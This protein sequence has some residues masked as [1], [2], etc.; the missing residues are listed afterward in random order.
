MTY[1]REEFI[2]NETIARLQSIINP[3]STGG[4]DAVDFTNDDNLFNVLKAKVN[5]DRVGASNG[6][7]CVTSKSLS[8]KW[9][10]STE[11]TRRTVK[12]T[13]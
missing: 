6:R 9:F 5:V 10:I 2:I 12:H 11:V 1:F 4:E 7:H 13:T 3:L 8:H